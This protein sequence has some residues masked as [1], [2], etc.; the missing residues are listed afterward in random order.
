MPQIG[1]IKRGREIGYKSLWRKYIWAACARCGK[2]RWSA[3]VVSR[4]GPQAN[5]CRSC[6]AGTAQIGSNNGHWKGGEYKTSSGYV[7]VWLP[8]SD[9]F[10][11]M[12]TKG[13]V[14]EHRLIIAESLGRCLQSWELVH[15]KNGIKDDNRIENLEVTTNGSH[16]REHAKGYRDGF[17]KGLVDGRDKQIQN[18]KEEI[19]LLKEG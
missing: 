3:L 1:E 5:S 9:F 17:Q 6:G 14:L 4:N 12:T 10:H 19:R 18:L 2:E 16:I 7:A 11:S 8:Q 15:H 13:H